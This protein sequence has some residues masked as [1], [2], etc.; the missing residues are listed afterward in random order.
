MIKKRKDHDGLRRLPGLR[1]SDGRHNLG[2]TKIPITVQVGAPLQPAEDIT[3]TDAAMRESMTTPLHR[4]QRCYR[5][6]PGRIGCR[7]GWAAGRRAWRRP[8]READEAAVRAA[9]R[10][11]HPSG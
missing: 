4:A 3:Q 2:R 10:S 6:R 8:L 5:T 9:T 1:T 7:A 11:A